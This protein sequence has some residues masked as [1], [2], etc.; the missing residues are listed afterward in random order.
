MILKASEG[1]RSV[2]IGKGNHDDTWHYKHHMW[3]ENGAMS[4]SSEGTFFSIVSY[5]QESF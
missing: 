2:K 3:K 4:Q 1:E 5:I